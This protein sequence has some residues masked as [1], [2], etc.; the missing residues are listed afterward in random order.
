MAGP[1]AVSTAAH[2]WMDGCMC[3]PATGR[4]G[5]GGLTTNTT[6]AGDNGGAAAPGLLCFAHLANDAGCDAISRTSQTTVRRAL[7]P[8]KNCRSVC[9]LA[10]PLRRQRPPDSTANNVVS[11]LV[12]LCQISPSSMSL[13]PAPGLH[14]AVKSLHRPPLPEP[15]LPSAAACSRC[16]ACAADGRRSGADSKQ[17][18]MRST[19]ACSQDGT[20]AR[21]A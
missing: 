4:A 10:A 16:S 20:A 21:W 7:L 9:V 11:R 6:D 19:T 18:R 5:A 8:Q 2:A 15:Q 17:S 12:Q 13:I 3:L 14:P 1:C